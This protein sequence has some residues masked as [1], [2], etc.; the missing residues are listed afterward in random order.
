MGTLGK[1]DRL[2][3]SL[4]A[5]TDETLH[6]AKPGSRG[7]TKRRPAK[8][9]DIIE[10]LATIRALGSSIEAGFA[11]TSY[12]YKE[13][14]EFAETIKD[15]KAAERVRYRIDVTDREISEKHSEEINSM[16]DEAEKL[17]DDGFKVI[18]IHSK[19]QVAETNQEA[20]S[21]RGCG[22]K[23]FTS[24]FWTCVGPDGKVYPCGHV[25]ARDT[26][27][28]G[29]LF[30]QSLKKIWNSIARKNLQ[31]CLPNEKCHLCSPFSLTTNMIGDWIEKE[32]ISGEQLQGFYQK[33]IA[34]PKKA[35]E[36]KAA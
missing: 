13:I 1:L 36:V 17:S 22:Y 6:E 3:A 26:P 8:I 31:A 2:N 34:E 20:F 35:K 32:G 5:I 27:S 33:Y 10:G 18:R 15:R 9:E 4:D 19:E 21:S 16:L 28:Y 14:V 29:N 24:Y 11:I 30:E 23:C 7:N 25:V 12:N